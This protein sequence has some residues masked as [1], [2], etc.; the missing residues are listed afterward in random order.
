MSESDQ[1]CSSQ[2]NQQC[3]NDTFYR[4]IKKIKCRLE[5]SLENYLEDISE[6][7]DDNQLIDVVSSILWQFWNTHLEEIE[8]ENAQVI[9]I[10]KKLCEPIDL[11]HHLANALAKFRVMG[12][13]YCAQI[14][15]ELKT[16]HTKPNM[17]SCLLSVLIALED[18][19]HCFALRHTICKF[20]IN[21]VRLIKRLH[22]EPMEQSKPLRKTS[23]A[24]P[25]W[26]PERQSDDILEAVYWR[27]VFERSP[28]LYQKLLSRALKDKKR[29]NRIFRGKQ[30]L[31]KMPVAVS[32]RLLDRGKSII[33]KNEA[34]RNLE[35]A[36]A[37]HA[38]LP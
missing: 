7:I 25:S 11:M 1:I 37:R 28:E 18:L 31:A 4:N 10:A 24:N 20:T 35:N 30:Y 36:A 38:T 2:A 22:R 6:N 32:N 17:N 27:L 21:G 8:N 15:D 29:M 12:K 16:V 9:E 3:Y 5:D 34:K 23:L 26:S 13:M 14:A 19:S 33:I